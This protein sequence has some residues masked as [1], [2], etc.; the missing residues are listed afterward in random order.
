M[1]NSGSSD[2]CH[3]KNKKIKKRLNAKRRGMIKKRENIG[4]ND[5]STTTSTNS[6]TNRRNSTSSFDEVSSN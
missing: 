6:T 2:N 1:G 5:F 3:D 4:S